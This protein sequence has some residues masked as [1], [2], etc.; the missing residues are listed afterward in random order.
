MFRFLR[1]LA[2]YV[3][4]VLLFSTANAFAD[5]CPAGYHVQ[6][7][8]V[9]IDY[10][11][12]AIPAR[13]EQ[14]KFNS[15]DGETQGN[16]TN[17]FDS[18]LERG[19]WWV[20]SST[21][22]SI[23]GHAYCSD[24]DGNGSHSYADSIVINDNGQHCWCQITS[25]ATSATSMNDPHTDAYAKYVYF[26]N[27]DKI[28]DGHHPDSAGTS[29]SWWCPRLCAS[30]LRD[31]QSI[32]TQPNFVEVMYNSV[33][34]CA[35]DVQET[36]N[37]IGY[38]L[39]DNECKP[40]TYTITYKDGNGNVI[41]KF[42]EDSY[43]T[44]YTVESET[45]TLPTPSAPEGMD[46]VGWY[47]NDKF[48]GDAVE[49]IVTG[50]TENKVL[51]AKFV[52]KTTPQPTACN[53]WEHEQTNPF[54]EG[55]NGNAGVSCKKYVS[56]VKP[57]STACIEHHNQQLI[58]GGCPDGVWRSS[59]PYGSAQ[60]LKGIAVTSQN[61]PAEKINY[62][63]VCPNYT[64]H[65]YL[66]TADTVEVDTTGTGKHCWCK[67][68]AYATH[69]SKS[70]DQYQDIKA[71]YVYSGEMKNCSY[72]TSCAETCTSRC[73]YY[74]NNID[75]L[76]GPNNNTATG[77]ADIYYA[78]SYTS[79]DTGSLIATVLSSPY[80]CVPNEY[81]IT[82][83]VGDGNAVDAIP[84]TYGELPLDLPVPT[85]NNDK[86][87]VGWY[88]N[89]QFSGQSIEQITK[90]SYGTKT[91]Y[92]K[93]GEP[94]VT[95]YTVYWAPGDHG[96]GN[97]T[98]LSNKNYGDTI[99]LP[100]NSF[101][102]EGGYV[103]DGWDCGDTIGDQ[104]VG[105]TFTM[106]AANVTCTAKWTTLTYPFSLTT[107][108]LL[109]NSTFQ[110]Y[111]SAAGTFYVD[112]GTDGA[113]YGIGVSGVK[114]TKNNL[115]DYPYQ[116]MYSSGG[117]K[118]IRF[119]GKATGYNNTDSTNKEAAAIRFNVSGVTVPSE[120]TA[121][122]ITSISGSL[123]KI[124]GTVAN[125]RT[126]SSGQPKFAYTFYAAHNMTGMTTPISDPNNPGMN[127]AL[128][129]TL[130]DGIYGAP[131]SGMFKNTFGECNGLSGSIPSEL[132]GNLSGAPKNEMFLGTF[133]RCRNLTGS[134]P[135][136]L[137]G[138]LYGAPAR[139]MFLGTFYGCTGIT[140]FG[141]KTY[142]PGTFLAN[143]ATN[144]SVPQTQ[145]MF[146]ETEL[147]NSCP[148]GTYNVTRE[149]FSDASKPWC[150][151]SDTLYTVSYL[152]G[153]GSGTTTN[154]N[155]THAFGLTVT[156]LTAD[157]CTAPAQ[158]V[159]AGWSCNQGIGLKAAKETFTMPA[160]NVTCTA[161]WNSADCLDGY[162]YNTATSNCDAVKYSIS[163]VLD[164]GTNNSN[165]PSSYTIETP[166]ITLLN[167]T[168]VGFEFVGWYD[169]AEFS[170]DAIEQIEKGST[171]DKVLYAKFSTQYIITY[172]LSIEKNEI[173]KRDTYIIED[174]D[175]TELPQP[176]KS[177]FQFTG[178]KDFEN[179][180]SV[181]S[182]NT[183]DKKDIELYATWTRIGCDDGYYLPAGSQICQRCPSDFPYSNGDN[184][185]TE[186]YCYAIC[187][188]SDLRY[189]YV[190]PYS[191]FGAKE[192]TCRYY[193]YLGGKDLFA[194]DLCNSAFYMSPSHYQNSNLGVCKQDW[195]AQMN[196]AGQMNNRPCQVKID[197][198]AEHFHFAPGYGQRLC[199]GDT[200]T[201]TYHVGNNTLTAEEIT[202]LGLP[203]TYNYW[204]PKTLPALED[205]ASDFFGWYDNA[206]FEGTPIETIER[207]ESGA[208]EFWARTESPGSYVITLN[209]M[210]GAT[211]ASTTEVPPAEYTYKSETIVIGTPIKEGY[212]F[213]SWCDDEEMTQNCERTKTIPTHSAGN[214]T[215]Y[216]KWTA[217]LSG[218]EC[219]PGYY[220]PQNSDNCVICDE[221]NYCTG[222]TNPVM[223][224]CPAGLVSPTGTVSA[225][226][227][228]K[229][230]LVGEDVLY[231]TQ[232][233]QTT[234][235]LAVK[236]DGKTYY[237]KTTPLS[238]ITDINAKYFLRT[239][240]DNIEYAIHDNTVQRRN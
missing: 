64:N 140:G 192:G 42:E 123:G 226:N 20:L 227:C 215:F 154:S 232:K 204:Q 121:Y 60:G 90:D 218:S 147:D 188:A 94:L 84:Y 124:F 12:Y 162:E 175:I 31:A 135:S 197:Q 28:E 189:D 181:E 93:W 133:I 223:Q 161:Q 21:Y 58:P 68:T 201:I 169:N 5:T 98:E 24:T 4:T 104:V 225:D 199:T 234:P 217:V 34:L 198:C 116:C 71:K 54:R 233:Q 8:L 168:K 63:E 52:A 48:S 76:I 155:S 11:D 119:D 23:K 206:G 61:G 196:M 33:P 56:N 17:G 180:E 224:P 74:M 184:A 132:F 235:A 78:S 95:T 92:A 182:I 82:F 229:I 172:Y 73:E 45:I 185:K 69:W 176:T 122:K 70:D 126:G 138:D 207:G 125:P 50:S 38:T 59:L 77:V 208:K 88:D 81:T 49:Q 25:V 91:L 16:H 99:T 67:I 111:I 143:I 237:A 14:M 152:C 75:T 205:S 96:T 144:T 13:G 43:A 160:A 57:N 15:L 171:E 213:D 97:M 236:L 190:Y 186:G 47:D 164:G 220:L 66:P 102:E 30:Y 105:A 3:M 101:Y 134:I 114:I 40:I 128:P 10:F 7:N 211:W 212:N 108:S 1:F 2:T 228:G 62:S 137:F 150:S 214:K 156:T 146:F 85:N 27:Q 51:Y 65:P 112:C 159:F 117:E 187:K 107:K 89:A 35:P 130:F 149:Q 127:Y 26:T 222:G 238:Q 87:F 174:A 219:E 83:N 118:T 231:L 115:E 139:N 216:A 72:E 166:T 19:S 193:A 163:Y 100:A 179:D 202:N 80:E 53:P 9:D 203:E 200:Y 129:P 103:F 239:K 178:W 29:C 136:E 148:A 106:P 37:K 41:T 110:F 109:S 32:Y 120:S 173:F 36:C 194:S 210:T 6:Q 153:D 170:G 167:P 141:N 240:I 79:M 191:C 113:L 209:N 177:K 39:Q 195:G 157:S 151:S 145:S 18:T 158:K 131:S 230:M 183:E 55:L 221:N 46:F 44:T 22:A 165:N 142:V 86:T